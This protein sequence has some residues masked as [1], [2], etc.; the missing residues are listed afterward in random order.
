MNTDHIPASGSASTPKRVRDHSAKK[1]LPQLWLWVSVAI[2]IAIVV[3][4]SVAQIADTQPIELAVEIEPAVL[5]PFDQRLP[6]DDHLA[7]EKQAYLNNLWA[8]LNR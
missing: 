4:V 5:D 2:A 1:R 3:I 7:T 8:R 6:A